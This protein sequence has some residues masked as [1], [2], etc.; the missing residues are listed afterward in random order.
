MTGSGSSLQT[1]KWYNNRLNIVS[2]VTRISVTDA[3]FDAILCSEA[4]K[5]IT[6]TI[7]ALI[8]FAPSLKS[9]PLVD[10]RYLQFYNPH[11]LLPLLWLKPLLMNESFNFDGFGECRD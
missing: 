2:H 7:V 5:Y 3:S 10:Q 1:G 11:S 8:S 4:F 6:H 9:S